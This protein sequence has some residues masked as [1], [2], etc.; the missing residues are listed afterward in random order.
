MLQLFRTAGRRDTVRSPVATGGVDA[1]YP[2]TLSIRILQIVG[3][4]CSHESRA[5]TAIAVPG[6][7]AGD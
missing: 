2:M 5:P 4:P 6:G 7:G 1:P 3:S